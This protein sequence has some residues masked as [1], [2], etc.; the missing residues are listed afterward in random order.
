LAAVWIWPLRSLRSLRCQVSEHTM[1]M[2][3]DV[4][5]IFCDVGDLM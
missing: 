1:L 2:W 3:C 5:S 4:L